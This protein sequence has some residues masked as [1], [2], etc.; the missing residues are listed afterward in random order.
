MNAFTHYLRSYVSDIEVYF[1]GRSPQDPR[2]F[3][4]AMD[5]WNRLET[6][7]GIRSVA[8]FEITC[9]EHLDS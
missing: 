1:I 4:E 9:K 8:A 5:W 7:A 2:D 6:Q 3:S